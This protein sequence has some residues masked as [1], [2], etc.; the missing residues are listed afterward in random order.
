METRNSVVLWPPGLWEFA[1]VETVS[2]KAESPTSSLG[3][4]G[5]GGYYSEAAPV[6]DRLTASGNQEEEE[7]IGK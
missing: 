2:Q 4:K 6:A 5:K 7:I 1:T 3:L